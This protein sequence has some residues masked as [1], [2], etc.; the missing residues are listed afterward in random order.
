MLSLFA[1]QRAP[2]LQFCYGLCKAFPGRFGLFIRFSEV[3][4]FGHALCYAGRLQFLI[5]SVLAVITLDDRA[6]IWIP[7]GGPPGA[8]RNTNFA[9]N[10]TQCIHEDDAILG[11]FLHGARGAHGDT[12][13][14]L[15]VKAGDK[16]IG[17][18]R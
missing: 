4:A 3:E 10:A 6:R 14:A 13:W 12:G 17:H 16:D 5:H 9:T 7:L 15:T 18:A 2:A 8:G 1:A 11:P